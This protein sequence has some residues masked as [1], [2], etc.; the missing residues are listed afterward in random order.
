MHW[1]CILKA[2]GEK[3]SDIT[4]KLKTA[5]DEWTQIYGNAINNRLRK[6]ENL[7]DVDNKAEAR[8]NLEIIGDN[9]TTHYHDDR[10]IPLIEAEEA[11]RKKEDEYTRDY[12]EAIRVPVGTILAFAGDT[13]KIPSG[14]H[15]CDGTNGTPDL[16]DRFLQGSS[17]PK[18]FKNAGLPNIEAQIGPVQFLGDNQAST[19]SWNGAMNLGTNYTCG[20]TEWRYE[21]PVIKGDPQK[22]W[23]TEDVTRLVELD[24]HSPSGNGWFRILFNASK[25]NSIYGNSSTVQPPAYTVYYIMRI[26]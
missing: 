9:N 20:R 6:D 11:A 15:I 14:W 24:T 26:K 10:Y 16:R 17:S 13:S 2:I 22:E 12:I 4:L 18:Q 23:H 19:G 5:D 3:M 1:L 8:K 7:S 25:A 21:Y